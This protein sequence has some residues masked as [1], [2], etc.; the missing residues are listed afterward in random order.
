VNWDAIGAIAEIVGAVAVVVTLAYLARE[1]R[2]NTRAGKAAAVNASHVSL[3]ENRRSTL[4]SA[5]LS[6]I[7]ISGGRNP[8]ELSETERQRYVWIMLNVS[9]AMLDIYTQTLETNFSPETWHTQGVSATLRTLGSEGGR[10]F[11]ENFASSYP[12]GF[13]QEVDRILDAAR[14]ED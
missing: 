9:D 2:Q 11:W 14:Q 12:K 7:F 6:T 3:R 10:W 4:A 1:V 13:R 8:L 5:E